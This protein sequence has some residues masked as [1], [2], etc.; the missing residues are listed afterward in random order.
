MT[1][2]KRYILF[3][4]AALV[5]VILF[6]MTTSFLYAYEG[7]DAA[8]F[9]QMGLGVLKGK[10]LYRDLFDNKGPLLFLLHALGLALGGNLALLIMQAISLTATFIIW[11]KILALRCTERQRWIRM[12]LL[13]LLLLCFYYDGDLSEEWC[14]PWASWP[15]L[16]YLRAKDEKRS[17]DHKEMFL[18]GLCCGV[19]AFIRPNNAVPFVGF[20][21]YDLIVRLTK[22]EV[23]GFFV[24]LLLLLAGLLVIALPIFIY[25]YA[26]AGW[27]GVD[28]MVYGAFLS[29]FEYM[30]LPL[31]PKWYLKVTYIVIACSALVL[32]LLN[33]RKE[34]DLLIPAILS[35]A[36]FYFSFGH[37]YTWHY[38]ITLLPLFAVLMAT[39]PPRSVTAEAR[40]LRTI[41]M[42]LAIMAIPSC[43]HYMAKP[44]GLMINDVVLQR[45]PYKKIYADFHD[46]VEGIPEVERDSICVYNVAALGSGAMQHEGLLRCNRRF[47]WIA[48]NIERLNREEAAKGGIAPLWVMASFDMPYYYDD[49][50]VFAEMYDLRYRFVA[51]MTYLEKPIRLSRKKEILIYRRKE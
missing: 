48:Q 7:G 29:N 40:T 24:S 3:F 1:K 47:A 23:K 15:I 41:S 16:A 12:G 18:T 14:L 6:S 28:D 30:E 43:L 25:F 46:C 44:V 50:L 34:R 36:L 17:L 33:S 35:Y 2:A 39:F 49:S 8:L 10:V 22:K 21:V 13:V 31:H 11:D 5:F 4:L 20:I 19:I 27:S 45:D 32:Q 38:L 26:I 51:D 37:R 42:V 9:K